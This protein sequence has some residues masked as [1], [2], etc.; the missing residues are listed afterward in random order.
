VVT[1]DEQADRTAREINALAAA[2]ESAF[3]N[4]Q[5]VSALDEGFQALQRAVTRLIHAHVFVFPMPEDNH[6][7]DDD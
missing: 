3:I 1:L 2:I 7:Q 6:P 5:Q 4:G